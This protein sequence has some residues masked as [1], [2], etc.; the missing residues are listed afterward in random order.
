MQFLNKKK[1]NII[2]I[3][4][5][6]H[7]IKY[8]YSKQ[9]KDFDKYF[10]GSSLKDFIKQ[11]NSPRKI[12]FYT[13][14][15]ENLNEFVSKNTGSGIDFKSAFNYFQELANLKKL[16]LSVLKGAT[17][18][19]V[20]NNSEDT[21]SKKKKRKNKNNEKEI[22]PI[23]K[24]K[25]NNGDADVTLDPGRYNPR[26]DYILRRYPC[27]YLGK[28]KTSIDSLP[29][30]N[31]KKENVEKNINKSLNKTDVDIDENDD[32]I[33]TNKNSNLKNIKK[34]KKLIISYS[35]RS[36]HHKDNTVGNYKKIN[37]KIRKNI[38]M[39]NKDEKKDENKKDEE[40]NKKV[41]IK[42]IK[43]GSHPKLKGVFPLL[44]EQNTASSWY[45][46]NY[47]DNSK[48]SKNKLIND[49]YRTQ[50]IFRNDRRDLNKKLSSE[51]IKCLVMFNKMLGR[52]KT[53]LI[54][55]K[56]ESSKIPYHP[57]YNFNR[58]HVPATIFKYEKNYQ[59][60]KKYMTGKI[61]R[62]YRLNPEEYF[63][64]EYNKNKDGEMSE[65]YGKLFL[66]L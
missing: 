31:N 37:I 21:K 27:A 35:N 53:H 10:R 44:K 43:V 11:I 52:E 64:F 16:P 7:P 4:K 55:G 1:D 36:I 34:N 2:S 61:I 50:R 41:G 29:E 56:K 25:N 48:K 63:V 13:N 20:R 26:Y 38:K 12:E 42:K 40:K 19:T 23:N 32:N 62:S 3:I 60:V 14:P 54:R 57:D 59:D 49:F 39:R 6:L 9:N 30:R 46:T 28:P 15:G 66:K 51:N 47:Y 8:L 65:K 24:M 33:K 45:N 17:A 58:P 18:K 5:S 22:T